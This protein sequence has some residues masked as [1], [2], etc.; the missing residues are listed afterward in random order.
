[1]KIYLNKN[2]FD[3]ALDRIRFLFDEFENIIV[4]ISGG[5][6][7]TV[8]LHLALQIAK[9]KNRLPLKVLFIDQEAEW[10]S[11]IDYIKDIMYMDFIEPIWLQIPIKLFNATSHEQEWL[12]CWDESEK[13]KWIHPKD[14]ISIKNNIY[15]TDRFAKL[16]TNYLKV[17]YQNVN[18][19]YIA[20]VRTE[21]SPARFMALTQKKTYKFITWGK[22]LSNKFNHYTFFPIYDWS[23]TDIWKSIHDNNWKYNKIYDYQYQYGIPIV[24]MRVSNLHHETAVK[25][26]FY[27]HEVEKILWDKLSL[28]LKGINCAGNL[29]LNML[30]CPDELPYMFNSWTEYRDYLLDNLIQREE[31]KEKFRKTFFNHE[32]RYIDSVQKK[33]IKTE[34]VMILTNDFN[35]TKLNNFHSANGFYNKRY[36]IKNDTRNKITSD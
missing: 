6:D 30:K 10:Q 12:Q 1:M 19:C 4:N 34:I 8:I 2:V 23:Y 3:A 35:L 15:G 24:N 11:T 7:S 22:K 14:P 33:L 36:I 16:F 17:E 28:R 27:A 25:N 18:A 29:K 9:E 5:K 26:L 20:G 31:I 13:D 32:N 21:E